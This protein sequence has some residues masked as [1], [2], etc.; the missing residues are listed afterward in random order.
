V[1]ESQRRE[2]PGMPPQRADIIVAGT[3]VVARLARHLGCRQILVNDG[4]VRDGLVLAMINDLG[5]GGSATAAVPTRMDAVRRFARR[6]SLRA[7]MRNQPKA[8][9]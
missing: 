4:G 3:A 7:I 9:P 5:L 1:P 8:Q 2:I 6:P